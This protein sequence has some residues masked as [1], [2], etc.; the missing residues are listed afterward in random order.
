MTRVTDEQSTGPSAG[1]TGGL[2]YP[3]AWTVARA[4]RDPIDRGGPDRR[5]QDGMA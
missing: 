4:A 1:P 2:R 5:K 3:V